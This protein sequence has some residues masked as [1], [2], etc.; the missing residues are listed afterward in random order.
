MSS[1]SPKFVIFDLDGTL[2][3]TEP[4][5]TAA[6]QAVVGR[7]GKVYDWSVKRLIIG[8][9]PE[10]GAQIVVEKLQLPITPAEYLHE[11][12]AIMRE[13]C[14]SVPALPGAAALIEW[15]HQRGIPLGIGT[16]SERELCE[17]KLSSHAF[18]RRFHA[19]VCSD[20]PGIEHAKPEP[21]IFLAVA[22]QLGAAGADCLVFED[23]P[24]GVAA[25]LAAGMRVIAL[26][27]PHMRNEN[28][29]GAWYVLDSLLAV[30]PGLL[31]L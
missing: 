20:D 14:R 12:E 5:Y 9:A 26:P 31:G 8:G 21:D 15:L 6:T 27:D 7:F 22:A 18:A 29:D 16:S 30:T 2:I 10:L 1:S 23:T 3:D 25:A 24:K 4:L 19:I 11:R 13:L 17:I 28:F